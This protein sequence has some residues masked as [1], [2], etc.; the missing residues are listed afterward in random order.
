MA[1]LYL[2]VGRDTNLDVPL[3]LR[4]QK[5]DAGPADG[6]QTGGNRGLW[7]LRLNVVHQV[8]AGTHG[9]QNRRIRDWRALVAIDAA[10]HDR[11]KAQRHE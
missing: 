6:R 3:A 11:G 5:R 4:G 2:F 7:D 1:T 10:V 8:T 9:A